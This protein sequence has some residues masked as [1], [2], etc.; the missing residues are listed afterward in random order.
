MA[1]PYVPW[2]L[3]SP[4]VYVW[5]D[6]FAGVACTLL[7][8]L[9][10]ALSLA[11]QG[12]AANDF[13][14]PPRYVRAGDRAIV[15]CQVAALLGGV[16]SDYTGFCLSL[17]F[18]AHMLRLGARV[19]G[20]AM[21]LEEG[22]CV[23]FS[24]RVLPA[25]SYSARENDVID[26]TA[27]VVTFYKVLLTGVAWGVT[28]ATLMQPVAHGVVITCVFLLAL[29]VASALA[30]QHVP[31]QLGRAAKYVSDVILLEAADAARDRAAERA[32]P[33]VVHNDEYDDAGAD[34]DDD[35]EFAALAAGHLGGGGGA[36][37][38]SAA[39]LAVRI[40]G[41]LEK[42]QFS[43]TGAGERVRRADA[44]W[45]PPDAWAEALIVGRGPFG[46]LGCKGLPYRAL[47]RGC[48]KGAKWQG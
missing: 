2:H 5:V 16:A 45:A 30:V 3:Y 48:A 4:Q 47:Q 24:A 28:T 42:L 8:A 17:F 44:L 23:H 22:A 39:D 15:A 26:E 10:G 11:L 36:P 41:L 21:A 7:L 14:L 18:V 37:A 6:A 33:F 13:F 32:R 20:R 35:A 31:L 1:D 19:A 27:H 29:A 9:G 34:D 12:W 38:D 25:Y 40:D 43:V 46:F